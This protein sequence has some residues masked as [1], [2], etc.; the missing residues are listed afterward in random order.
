V[1]LMQLTRVGDIAAASQL[2]SKIRDVFPKNFSEESNLLNIEA[3]LNCFRV[4]DG[5]EAREG[6]RELFQRAQRV[7]RD[8]YRKLVLA[9]NLF[10]FDHFIGKSSEGS[11]NTENSLED[12]LY[13]LETS[14]IGFRYLYVLGYYNI[15]RYYEAVGDATNAQT[16]LLRIGSIDDSDSLLWRCAMGLSDP[17]GTEVEFLVSTPYMLAF[18]P[19]YQISPPSFDRRVD[20]ISEII[21]R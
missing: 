5:G 10:V 16:Y 20:K 6:T 8:E 2:L 4:K 19:N 7:C 15:M 13:L 12:L 21:S 1:L 3:L 11:S 9:S 18:L 14:T 17:V